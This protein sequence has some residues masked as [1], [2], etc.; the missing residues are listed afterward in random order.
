MQDDS[1]EG[2][3]GVGAGVVVGGQVQRRSL[4]ERALRAVTSLRVRSGLGQV[5]RGCLGVG[6]VVAGVAGGEGEV[7]HGLG[8]L[9]PVGLG[10]V[11]LGSRAA[12]T[13]R[14]AKARRA[15]R[16]A[17]GEGQVQRGWRLRAAAAA[18]AV[19]GPSSPSTLSQEQSEDW[20]EEEYVEEE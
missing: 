15:C 11:H 16:K 6:E 1:L 10:H 12:L 9:L 4:A 14:A 7:P 19:A 5:Q 8:S 3:G 17:S 2:G 20:P 18:A 13:R